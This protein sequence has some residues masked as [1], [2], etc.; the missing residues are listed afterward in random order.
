M[1][2]V[3]HTAGMAMT[4][5]EFVA[6]QRASE[7]FLSSYTDLS[8]ES[9]DMDQYRFN[10]VTKFHY[11]N[12]LVQHSQHINAK[13]IWCHGGEDFY[14]PQMQ[15]STGLLCTSVVEPKLAGKYRIA[16]HLKWSTMRRS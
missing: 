11:R 14:A 10:I 12:H 16:M 7:S 5:E 6:F 13:L 15:G 2:D 9:A 1:Y 3:M 8:K 4:S